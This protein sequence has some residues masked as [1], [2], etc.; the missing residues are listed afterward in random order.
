MAASDNELIHKAKNGDISA[1][2]ELIYR[3][4]KNVLSIALKYVK[5]EQDAK[6][7][8]QEVF[9]RVFKSLKKFEFRSEFSTWL[10]RITTNV[11][12]TYRSRKKKDEMISF[13]K[14]EKETGEEEYIEIE[15]EQSLSP[16]EHA[17][18]SET[19]MHL[20]KAIERLSPKQKMIFVLKH[21]EGYKIK[22]I[23]IM[24]KCG[25]GTVKK[26]LFD[27]VRKLR[28]WLEPIY[29]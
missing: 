13:I 7:I 22:D 21:Y 11:C 4:D 24:L 26:S 14:E 15:D 12:L 20:N 28:A 3:Y 6:D 18:N 8:Y 2:E 23:A 19:A 16:E 27:S 17:S 25:E 5:N 1:F 10:F 9:L 29:E